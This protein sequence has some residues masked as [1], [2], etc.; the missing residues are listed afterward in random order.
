ME[1]APSKTTFSL[2]VK[3]CRCWESLHVPCKAEQPL[4]GMEL[5]KKKRLKPAVNRCLLILDLNHL[6]HRS[7][8]SIQ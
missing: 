1:L 8:E 7:K 3:I 6:D 5:Q 2:R 4:Q